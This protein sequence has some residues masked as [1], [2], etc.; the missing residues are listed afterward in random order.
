MS[1]VPVKIDL[2]KAQQKKLSKG[3][4]VRVTK[5]QLNTGANTVYLHPLN[6]K[7][8]NSSKNG[9]NLSMSKGEV[10]Y[11]AD[12]NGL[13]SGGSLWDDIKSGI[14]KG[15]SFL[16]DS[17]IGTILADAAVPFASTVLGPAGATAARSILKSTTGVGLKQARIENMNRARSMKRGKDK[18]GRISIMPANGGSFRIN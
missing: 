13:I 7:K 17:G 8:A 10:L 9:F 16:K 4:S 5:S 3:L 15:F 18:I 12:K 14:S 11:T 1:Y 2:T 6:A